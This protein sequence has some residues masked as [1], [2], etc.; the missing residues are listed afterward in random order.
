MRRW[1][2]IIA[3]LAGFSADG[4]VHSAR[5]RIPVAIE[6]RLDDPPT[7]LAPT[8]AWWSRS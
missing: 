4:Y 7:G 6:R 3:L 1:V 5:P 8:A 2:C